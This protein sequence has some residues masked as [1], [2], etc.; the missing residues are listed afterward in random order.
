MSTIAIAITAWAVTTMVIQHRRVVRWATFPW[1]WR[2]RRKIVPVVRDRSR[3]DPDVAA[4]LAAL[5]SGRRSK[6]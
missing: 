5:R 4:K 2:S 6:P 1:R 3:F